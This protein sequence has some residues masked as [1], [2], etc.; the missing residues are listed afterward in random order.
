MTEI[1]IKYYDTF[2]QISDG[3]KT[4]ELRKKS[5]FFSQ[6]IPMDEINFVHNDDIIKCVIHSIKSMNY[7]ELIKKINLKNLNKHIKTIN[8]ADELYSS[9]YPNFDKNSEFIAIFFIKL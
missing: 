4:V 8:N 7:S 1:Y 5:K 6:L 3:I 9:Y 2:C